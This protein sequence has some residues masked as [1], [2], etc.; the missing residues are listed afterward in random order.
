MKRY[1]GRRILHVL[2]PVRFEG[3]VFNHESDSNYKVAMKTIDWLPECHHYVLVPTVNRIIETRPNVTL[4]KYNYPHNAV[5]NRS[6]FDAKS[7]LSVI[8]L[9]R[10]DIDFIFTDQPE[11]LYNVLVALM[12]KRYGEITKRLSFYHW[13]D[14]SASR[15]SPAIP[16]S[17]MRQLEAVNLS[18]KIFLHSPVS[19]DYME[20]NFKK[21]K[22][23]TFNREYVLKNTCYMPLSSKL[24]D[25]MQEFPLPLDKPIVVYNHRWNQSTGMNR[26][27]E[28]TES[29]K[30]KYLFVITDAKA[31]DVPS[32]YYVVPHFLN[33]NE[34]RWLLSK[35]LTTVC[36][37]DGY[38]TW[39]LS[40]Q[41]GI[42]AGLTPVVYR[43]SIMDYVLEN[44]NYSM[45][46]TKESFESM[47]ADTKNLTPRKQQLPKHDEK[48]KSNLLTTVEQL[49]D[50]PENMPK[51]ALAWAFYILNG[52]SY[53]TEICEQ[54]QPNIQLNS[55]W[56]Y[57]RRWLLTNGII[58]NPDS[59]YTTYSVQDEFRSKLEIMC[60][61]LNLHIKPRIRKQTVEPKQHKFF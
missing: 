42:L 60:G 41:D 37:V 4:L 48:F 13:I 16:H 59:K 32:G 17:Y 40:V 5:S 12:D 44:V 51:D 56:Q 22:A 3:D 49:I 24:S 47:L 27:L 31:E 18:D 34:Y 58:D 57:I 23:V 6:H 11:L 28:Y 19:I 8:D 15:G 46:T 45:F 55:V 20:T 2:S 52:I 39:N 33:Q 29:I 14:C 35:A 10:I 7:L 54:V 61:D 30:D 50:V 36:F 21:D 43:H 26:F 38:A 9:K 25:K 1:H 53:K